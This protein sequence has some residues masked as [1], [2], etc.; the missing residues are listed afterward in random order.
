MHFERQ[1]QIKAQFRVLLFNKASI[2]ILVKYFNYSNV[3]SIENTIKI[4]ENTRINEHAIKLEEDKQS[5][6]GLI[7]SLELVK[8]EILK[9]YI[10]IN[11][12]N[13]FIQLFMSSAKALILFDRKPNK[14]FR[15]YMDY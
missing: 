12:A 5:L 11:L 2:E 10:K 3:F 1:A 15:F 14:S 7:Y 13:N 8:L 6:F 4:Q 9:I